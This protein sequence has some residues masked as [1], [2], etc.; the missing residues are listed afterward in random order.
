[1]VPNMF[2]GLSRW[3]VLCM[4]VNRC[5]WFSWWHY[6]IFGS[7]LTIKTD[8]PSA[9]KYLCVG[10]LDHIT[11]SLVQFQTSQCDDLSV[12][13]HSS[14]G[15]LCHIDMSLDQLHHSGAMTYMGGSLLPYINISLVQ[16]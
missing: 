2:N 4:I 6:L 5:E 11:I 9:L 12:L 7:I 16:F 10:P 3:W 8:D 15:P 14:V 13:K 1:M